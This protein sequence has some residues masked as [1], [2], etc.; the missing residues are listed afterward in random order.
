MKTLKADDYV[1]VILKDSN[2]KLSERLSAH[3]VA[4]RSPIQLG[5]D[6]IVRREI[7]DL[8]ENTSKKNVKSLAVVLETNGGY[9]EVVERIYAVLRK[10]FTKVDFVV[11]NYAYSA[12]TVLVLSGDEIYM[13]YYS[14]LG[15]IDPQ[16]ENSEG[17]MVPGLGYLAK[18]DELLS[19]INK[20]KTGTASRA[21]LAYLI[22]KF[23]PATLF[24]LEQARNHSA[25][26]L[27]EWLSKHK[28]KDW[29]K[30]E[31][32]GQQVT[33]EMRQKRAEEI[34]A[35][36]CKAERWHSHGRGIDLKVLSSDEI[37]LKIIDFGTDD[38]LNK[39][40]RGY[41]DLFTD[42]SHK[43][44]AKSAIHTERGLRRIQ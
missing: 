39:L 32:G 30:T 41:Y 22:K 21:E 13:D 35:I 33:E 9:I 27:K 2:K 20:D 5:L 37:K 28:F 16:I 1:N 26:L 11:P 4:L 15:P 19:A 18:F 8:V 12:G 31:S 7:E 14:V 34:A 36:L 38:N 25:S 43:T 42:F 17:K 40:I 10:H 3:V 44:G 24:L 29:D 23:D 6:T